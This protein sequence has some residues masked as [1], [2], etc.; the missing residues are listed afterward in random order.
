[1]STAGEEA[2]VPALDWLISGIGGKDGNKSN[3]LLDKTFIIENVTN[4]KHFHIISNK[5]I[6]KNNTAIHSSE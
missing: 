4:L 6:K 1:M 5:N 2:R 3:G